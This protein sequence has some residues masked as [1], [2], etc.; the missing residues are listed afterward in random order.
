MKNTKPVHQVPKHALLDYVIARLQLKN[1][2]ALCRYIGVVPPVLSRIRHRGRSVGPQ[3]I[4][5]IH[6]ATGIPVA[7]IRM[8]VAVE[9]Q[10]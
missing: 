4:L 8:L 2:A 9:E 10:I 3:M 1:D 7:K 5:S 6:E